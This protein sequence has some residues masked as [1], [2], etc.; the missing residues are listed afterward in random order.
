MIIELYNHGF[1]DSLKKAEEL[2]Y[3][4]SNAKNKRDMTRLVAKAYGVVSTV[5]D[6]IVEVEV[7]DD[8]AECV[9]VEGA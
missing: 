1:I 8:D 3:K 9:V 4:A 7:E 6:L 5:N 2:L